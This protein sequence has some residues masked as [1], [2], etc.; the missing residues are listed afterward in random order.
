[1]TGCLAGI[2][3]LRN[4]SMSSE[5]KRLEGVVRVSRTRA[6]QAYDLTLPEAALTYVAA[7]LSVIPIC[8]D[9]SKG[10]PTKW[11]EYQERLA[12]RD[13]LRRWFAEDEYGIAVVSGRVSGNLEVEDVDDAEI[14]N[15]WWSAVVRAVPKVATAPRVRSP[16]GGGHLCVRSEEQVAGNQKL[17]QRT[18][19]HAIPRRKSK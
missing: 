12:T 17:A 3:S 2:F 7:G 16:K 6:D 11:R 15:P 13:E 5:A 1:M 19:K 14:L 10:P 8:R 18:V 9:G 4:R